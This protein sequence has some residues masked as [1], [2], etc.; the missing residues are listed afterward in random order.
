M[1]PGPPRC[2]VLGVPTLS[3]GAGFSC[4]S[5][6]ELF[7]IALSGRLIEA[8]GIQ[9]EREV[10]CA[11]LGNSTEF[12]QTPLL[13]QQSKLGS[14]GLHGEVLELH[15]VII[16]CQIWTPSTLFG[17]EEAF[18]TATLNISQGG[19]APGYLP[20]VRS[21]L[22]FPGVQVALF[23]GFLAVVTGLAAKT[24]RYIEGQL[25]SKYGTRLYSPVLSRNLESSMRAS[26]STT[27]IL[28]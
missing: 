20:R 25:R 14:T 8:V 9:R 12:Y 11:G 6:E 19:A 13:V 10:K 18:G 17:M 4:V 23:D 28:G 2:E 3:S 21:V 5:N 1:N 7:S 27:F 24:K 22:Y 16:Q 26:W 15:C